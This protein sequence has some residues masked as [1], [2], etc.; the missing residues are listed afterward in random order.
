MSIN[1]NIIQFPNKLEQLQE[2]KKKKII[3]IRDEIEKML[4]NYSK[5]YGDEW[6]VILAAGRFSSMR[7][8]QLEGSKKCTEFFLDCIKTQEQS[9]T[10]Q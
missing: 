3:R 2:D 7:L 1:T 8:Q 5:I 9:R 4:L 6:A 10:N